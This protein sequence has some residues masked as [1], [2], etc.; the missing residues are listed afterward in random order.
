MAK[1]RTTKASTSDAM[2]TVADALDK[3]YKAAKGGT[4]DATAAA[5]RALP[6]AS[7]FLS[8]LVYTTSYTLSYGVV[9]PTM[10]LARSIPENNS[11]VQGFVDGARAA[12]DR[13]DTWKHRRERR[14]AER[15]ALPSKSPATRKRKSGS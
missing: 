8:R 9:F 15:P 1:N 5:G 11:V 2:K 13:V 4:A 6:A 12:N 10:M 14:S 7:R 3:A